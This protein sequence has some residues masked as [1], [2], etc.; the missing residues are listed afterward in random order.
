MTLLTTN[1]KAESRASTLAPGIENLSTR[2]ANPAFRLD[3]RRSLSMHPVLASSMA[4]LSFVV[5]LLCGMTMKPMYEAE[6]LVHVQ[7][8][9]TTLLGG[10]VKPA[11]DSGKYDSFLQEQIQTMQRPDTVAAALERLPHSSW[12]EYGATKETAA[13]QILAKLK[14]ARVTTSYQVSLMLKGS[15]PRN[16]TD[17]VNA[18]TYAYL[19]LA[20]SEART[21]NQQGAGLLAEEHQRVANELRK[22]QEEQNGL[23]VNLGIANPDGE[24][25][26]YEGELTALREQLAQARTSHEAALARLNSLSGQ[27]QGQHSALAAEADEATLADP[28]L[29]A[30]KSTISER[31]ATLR[32]Q[33]SGMTPDNPLRR[34]NQEEL[35]EL[36]RSLEEMTTKLRIRNVRNL[37]EKLRA[38][39]QQ[40]GDLEA[41]ISS[42]LIRR[43]ANATRSTPK[44][45]RAAE[46]NEEIKRLLLRQIEIENAI[47]SLQ[48]EGNRSGAA[49]LTLAAK[50]PTSPEGNRRRLAFLASF[51]LALV[52]GAAAASIA[53]KFDPRIYTGRDLEDVL[54]FLPLTTLPAHDEVSDAVVAEHVLR[55]AGAVTSAHRNKG[56]RSFLFA[57]V[58]G[59]SDIQ[60]LS[61]MLI[62]KLRHTGINACSILAA[63]LLLPIGPEKR[64]GAEYLSP[65]QMTSISSA[66]RGQGFL[67]LNLALL[68]AHHSLV[69]VEATQ[70]FECAQTEY[71]A[72]CIDA[73]IL[74]VES[75][76]STKAEL[77]RATESVHRLHV[78][79]IGFVLQEVKRRY[80]TSSTP[81]LKT[82]ETVA[83]SLPENNTAPPAQPDRDQADQK[84]DAMN[85]SPGSASW[86]M[87]QPTLGNAM[88]LSV[89]AES[90]EDTPALYQDIPDSEQPI[91]LSDDTGPCNQIALG[92]AATSDSSDLIEG[93]WPK[94]VAHRKGDTTLTSA[95]P[96]TT[97]Q[98][99]IANVGS[100]G[101]SFE[102]GQQFEYD[103]G[104]ADTKNV[105]VDDVRLRSDVDDFGL[106]RESSDKS[107]ER[108]PER[109]QSEYSRPSKPFQPSI[110]RVGEGRSDKLLASLREG[111]QQPTPAV[112]FAQSEVLNDSDQSSAVL[113]YRR[114]DPTSTTQHEDPAGQEDLLSRQWN[115]L[116]RFQQKRSF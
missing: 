4:A 94:P 2:P 113:L 69:L 9:P 18:I 101:D 1:S 91:S 30:L 32:G 19:D 10:A 83:S 6:A 51:P 65:A 110:N 20:Q 7:P 36:D 12:A 77:I 85:A 11:F 39:L 89:E 49:R 106:L 74:V 17:V 26:P 100:E 112:R 108:L 92:F 47:R 59:S 111:P 97:V 55:L 56:S 38:D 102:I 22:D 105:G 103:S 48:L 67:E 33:M 78:P 72:R 96:K 63:D 104:L 109:D 37:Q 70:P 16:V 27:P 54:K 95:V 23:A 3:L 114:E 34:R 53:R 24:S 66:Q 90:V 42:H 25:D 52:L 88:P 64:N 57:A 43:T 81:L 14:I 73:T 35:A 58:S 40:T 31:R 68:Q 84:A 44:L 116:S 46:L 29:S 50:V 107:F 45:Q 13:E 62:E 76:V 99:E 28:E 41:S 98:T 21:E 71:I 8:E 75:A 86:T 82:C 5:F 115:L 60:P 61:R 93:S 15:D 87:A 79:G 80:L